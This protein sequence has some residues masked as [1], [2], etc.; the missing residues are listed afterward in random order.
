M[1]V[2]D[3]EKCVGCRTCEVTCSTAHFGAVSPSLSRIRVAK[4]E[5][6]GIDLAV[7]CVGCEEK[8]CLGCS[9]EALSVGDRGEIRVDGEAC[10]ACAECVDSCPIGAVGFHDDAPLFCDLCDGEMRCVK[11]CP[12][13]ALRLIDETISL[14]PYPGSPAQRRAA[15]ARDEAGALRAAWA[16]GRRADS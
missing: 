4:L 5:E 1:I 10:S 15:W 14:E 6:I 12:T 8:P 11:N 7:A 13:G 2:C 3:V 16:A 9:S